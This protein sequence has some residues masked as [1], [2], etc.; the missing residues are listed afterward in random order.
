MFSV[1]E[2]TYKIFCLCESCSKFEDIHYVREK[3]HRNIPEQI[4]SVFIFMIFCLECMKGT[5]TEKAFQRLKQSTKLTAKVT[6][7]TT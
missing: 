1:S 2:S 7:T 6:N 3:T 5:A 4:A